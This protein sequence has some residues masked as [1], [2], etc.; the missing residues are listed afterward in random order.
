MQQC[1]F[2]QPVVGGTL[3]KD[4]SLSSA[5]HGIGYLLHWIMVWN[6][7]V[8]SCAPLWPAVCRSPA[9]K[10]RRAVGAFAFVAAPWCS[11]AAQH[12]NPAGTLAALLPARLV[13]LLGALLGHCPLPT[14][15]CHLF[16]ISSC[17]KRCESTGLLPCS[18]GPWG[19]VKIEGF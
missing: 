4:R 2:T 19:G 12:R 10:C 11:C 18:T 13:V 7:A 5:Y 15:S 9:G 17:G 3:E 6:D 8:S 16:C 14:D 1:S